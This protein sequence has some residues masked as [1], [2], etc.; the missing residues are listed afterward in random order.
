[1]RAA[2]PSL[3]ILITKHAAIRE[4]HGFEWRRFRLTTRER[5]IEMLDEVVIEGYVSG[6]PWTHSG[7]ED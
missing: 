6:R 2:L 7:V 4:P 3:T 5:E 1:L